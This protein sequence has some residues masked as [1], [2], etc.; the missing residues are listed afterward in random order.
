M[1]FA[2]QIIVVAVLLGIVAVRWLNPDAWASQFFQMLWWIV[3]VLLVVE[4]LAFFAP[5]LM[6]S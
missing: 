6:A 1:T 3:L 4:C 5:R 2:G